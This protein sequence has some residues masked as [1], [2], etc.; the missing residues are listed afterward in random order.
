MSRHVTIIGG[1]VIGLST[2]LHCARRG[3]R[4]TVLDGN[5]EDHGGCSYG[6]A[7]MIVPSH[8]IPL[9]APGMVALGLKWMWNP[10]SPFYIKPRLDAG[11][12][13]WAWKFWRSA[14]AAHVAHSA[15]LLRDLSFA[16]K[17]LF[18][19]LA[20]ECG[21][22]FQLVRRGL[23]ML[24]KTQHTLD[25]EGKTAELANSLGV[26]AEV[27][28]AK[29]T[30]AK[31]PDA[32]LDVAGSVC[33][34]NDCHVT[35]HLFLG[36]LKAMCLKAGVEFRWKARVTGIRA[37]DSAVHSVFTEEGEHSIDQVVM[38][39]G[40]W[41]AELVRDL[42]LKIPMQAGKGYSLTLNSPVKQL[43]VCS[44]LTEARVAVTPMGGALR[45]GGTMEIAGL[46]ER[47]TPRRV[48]GIIKSLPQYY[49]EF[50]A[51]DFADIEPWCGLRPCSPDG[52]PYVGR[53][54]KFSNVCVATGHAMMGLSLGP[55]TGQMVAQI[56]DGEKP[57]H[58][59]RKMS[60][61]RFA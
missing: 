48:Q 53:T 49:P 17:A 42:G 38:C 5:G 32:V 50:A 23:L 22:E 18:E 46:N 40:S 20:A 28:N 35:P 30:A 44:I 10:E 41:T 47:I 4:V 57:A 61:D 54:A 59:L 39:A 3:H 26:A 25:E 12:F 24:C 37:S 6:N 55:I 21:N 14:T 33:F 60:P 51:A 9:A 7:G 43:Q 36:S 29:E 16:S 58:D 34:P 56:L 52:L 19:Q 31:E 11:L 1:G 13:D 8:F 45:V 15:P 27:L 2:A